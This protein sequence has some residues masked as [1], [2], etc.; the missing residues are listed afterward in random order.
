MV[1][2]HCDAG[3]TERRARASS[4]AASTL[5]L[6]ERLDA[7]HARRQ[8]RE[9]A[10]ESSASNTSS[11]GAS[12]ASRSSRKPGKLTAAVQT[13]VREATG[14]DP[15]LSTSGGTSDGRFIA[16]YGVDVVELGPL[17][18]T[19]HSSNERRVRSTISSASRASTS[20]SPDCC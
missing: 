7:R 13:A 5:R 19:I 9:R 12:P 11:A 8:R 4:S 2:V 1:N 3:A 20:A 16:P 15:E 10:E 18:A 6:L 14:L 17:N